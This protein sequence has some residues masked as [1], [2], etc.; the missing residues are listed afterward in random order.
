M[1]RAAGTPVVLLLTLA[2][3]LA[4]LEA[5][6]GTAAVQIDTL[7]LPPGFSIAVYAEVP[8]ARSMTVAPDGTV[9]VGSQS[10][11]VHA[12]VDRD[13]EGRSDEVVVVA[14]DLRI[15][16]GVAFK[17]GSLF[18]AD[19]DRVLRYDNILDYVNKP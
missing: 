4:G 7:R 18:V 5:Q 11:V 17:D 9:F 12:I 14:N 19:L 16:N 2:L 8:G 15:A 1:K 10:S 6:R 3:A 13:H